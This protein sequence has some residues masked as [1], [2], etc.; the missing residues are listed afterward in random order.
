MHVAGNAGAHRVIRR[1][2]ESNPS[3]SNGM[4]RSPSIDVSHAHVAFWGRTR[5]W[6]MP[7]RSR[8]DDGAVIGTAF[9]RR[10]QRMFVR[11]GKS[12]ECP[13]TVNATFC[14]SS[15]TLSSLPRAYE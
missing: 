13:I 15:R 12:Q 5:R 10:L 1:N 14:F 11:P 3:S 7:T 8:D 9:Y 4:I 2:D 6:T